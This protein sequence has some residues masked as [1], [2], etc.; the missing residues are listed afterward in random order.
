MFNGRIKSLPKEYNVLDHDLV[1]DHELLSEKEVEEL[2]EEED[3]QLGSLP[4]VLK[5]DP[6]AKELDA[7]PGDVLKV[8]RESPTAGKALAYRLVID[9]EL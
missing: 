3:I 6:V 4:K 7:E 9:E 1:P 5:R 2:K 8:I